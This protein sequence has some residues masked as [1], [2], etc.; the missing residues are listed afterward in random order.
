[1]NGYDFLEHVLGTHNDKWANNKSS[2]IWNVE[3]TAEPGY[4]DTGLCDGSTV[5]DILW[6]QLISLC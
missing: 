2:S 3:Y 5:S 1:M 6:Y 4:N